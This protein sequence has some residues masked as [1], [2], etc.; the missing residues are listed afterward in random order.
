MT[1]RD[2]VDMAYAHIVTSQNG[3]V[4]YDD[5]SETLDDTMRRSW[6]D[7][8]TWGNTRAQMQRVARQAPTERP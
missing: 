4:D 1:A 6:V 2:I 5:L 7:R 3:L 8:E